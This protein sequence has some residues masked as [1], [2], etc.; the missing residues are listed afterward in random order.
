MIKKVA[1]HVSFQ[2]EMRQYTIKHD[3]KSLRISDSDG[4]RFGRTKTEKV[5]FAFC[6][7]ITGNREEI[8]R[9]IGD[10]GLR[11]MINLWREKVFIWDPEQIVLVNDWTVI[12]LIKS[13]YGEVN[14]RSRFANPND[15]KVMKAIS[16]TLKRKVEM[17]ASSDPVGTVF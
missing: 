12:L 14:T 15:E 4:W 10:I 5:N 13:A 17:I 11:F 2:G 16:K 6:E 1:V 9:S 8:R 3:D 7:V